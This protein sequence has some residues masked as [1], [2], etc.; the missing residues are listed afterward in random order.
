V[1]ILVSWLREFIDVPDRPEDLAAAMS[2]RGFA[3]EGIEP[4]GAG[5]A[6][7]DFEVTANRPDCLSVSGIA[8]EVGVAYDRSV[9]P[10]D[11]APPLG[12]RT[13]TRVDDAD[14]TV[15]LE[16]A[17]LCPRYVGAVADVTVRESP[18]W[19]QARLRAAGVR[20]TN[21]VVDV[22]NYVLLEL[23][24]PMHAFDYERIEGRQIR[25]REACLGDTLLTLD[26]KQRALSPSMLVIADR[27]QPVAVAGVMGGAHSE[28]RGQTTTIVLESAYFAPLS[29]RRTSKALGLKTEA[30]MRFERGADPSLPLMAMERACALLERIGAGTARGTVVDCF[31]TAI[32]PVTL[33]L[34][35]ARVERLL[36][37]SVPDADVRRILEGLEFSLRDT[38][39]GWHVTVPTRR[40]DVAREA[41]L[42]EEITRHYG[43]DRLPVSFPALAVA[44]PPLDPRV[45]RARRLRGTLTGLGFSEAVTF[46]FTSE[47]AAAPFATEGVVPI[48]NPLSEAFAVLRPSLL[49]GLVESA[50]RNV[51]RGRHDVQ[52]FEVGSQF[53]PQ[54]G[55]TQALSFIWTGSGRGQHW[56]EP[57]REVD[58]FDASGVISAIADLMDANVEL[59]PTTAPFL[60][61]GRAATVVARPRSV[62]GGAAAREVGVVGLLSPRVGE[63]LDLPA[64]VAA[65]VAQLDLDTL[66][67]RPGTLI[68]VPPPRF[69]S[70]DRDIS[71]LLGDTTAARS[72]RDTIEAL[73]LSILAELREFDRYAG[74]G[75]PEGKFSLSIR[76]TFRSPDRTLTDDEVQDAMDAV[77][78]G[79]TKRHGAVQR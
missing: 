8:R 45:T 62:S 31:P 46:G 16:N 77:L 57:P 67:G 3:V 79:L 72:V 20:P 58:L 51:R 59:Q 73:D 10:L 32:A 40:V 68:A 13:L 2:V 30:S 1:K 22:T 12:T 38:D 14:L 6:V 53:S 18:A 52:L 63:A 65:Y 27:T 33:E 24:Q 74:K 60:V 23:G 21:N 17:A 42:V 78:A 5:D 39:A 61:A 11:G 55:E 41:D 69:P 29:V 4:A 44:P 19:M 15:V 7:L 71:I 9:R 64:G 48:K 28:V 56:S 35:R 36:G 49:P 54:R 50:G 34:R 70:I 66:G 25:V 37:M 26:G 76:L 43:L 47:P 75:V